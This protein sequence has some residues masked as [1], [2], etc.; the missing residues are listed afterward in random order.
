M[1]DG[2]SGDDALDMAPQRAVAVT[3]TGEQAVLDTAPSALAAAGSGRVGVSAVLSAVWSVRVGRG[4]R[5]GRRSD[6]HTIALNTALAH[7]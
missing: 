7:V 2:G 4:S 5:A 1:K 3:A 6:L